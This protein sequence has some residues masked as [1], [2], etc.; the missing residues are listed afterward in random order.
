MIRITDIQDS[1]LHLVGWEQSITSD[2]TIDD[3]LTETESGLYY[4]N[5]HALLTLQNIKST[6]PDEYNWQFPEW[7]E[8]AIY[9]KDDK[10]KYNNVVYIATAANQ[11]EPPNNLV[12]WAVYDIFSDYLLRL[13][14]AGIANM[15]QQFTTNKILSRETK[16]LLEHRTFFDGAGRLASTET[17]RGKIVGFEINPVRAMGVTCKVE[18][19]GLQFS[20]NGEVTVYLFHS[21]KVNPI[22]TTTLDYTGA[23]SFQ[24]FT[25]T[26]WY[27]PYI[28]SDTNSGGSWFICYNQNDLSNSMKAVNF[29]KDWSR[30]PCGTCNKGNLED[31]RQ[32]TKYIMISPFQ[33]KALNTFAQY[34]ELWDI[35]TNVY[36]NTRNY[37]MNCE[38]SVGCDISDFIINQRSLFANVLQKQVAYN[39]L[40]LMALNPEV[41]VNRNQFNV[42]RMDLLYE[43]DGNTAGTYRGG[44]GFELQ[45]AYNAISIDTLGLDRICLSCNNKGVKYST[46]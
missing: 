13:T 26:D 33:V 23:G 12:S 9:A 40:R 8:T 37:G 42:S 22:K 17:N 2:N 25:L 32:I 7:S 16:N 5:A 10:V 43:L 46:V 4:Q 31:W 20:N 19:L 14:R 44:L 38:I 6:M 11:N 30:E 34:P 36:T 21:S 3:N 28:S 24:W 45:K 1:L 39:I 15:V 29:T 27:L 18:K 41:R 35:E